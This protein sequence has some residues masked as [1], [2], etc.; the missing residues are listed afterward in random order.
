MQHDMARA[1]EIAQQ[2]EIKRAE[3]RP[4]CIIAAAATPAYED[5]PGSCTDTPGP[6]QTRFGTWIRA[7]EDHIALHFLLVFRCILPACLCQKARICPMTFVTSTSGYVSLPHD[8]M[9]DYTEV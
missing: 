6:V 2:H 4:C 7:L 8:P 3:Q 5:E 9:P 1:S